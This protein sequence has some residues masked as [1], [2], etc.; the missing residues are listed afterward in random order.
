MR[1]VLV[2]LVAVLLIGA[3]SSAQAER[4]MFIIPT[5][6]DGYG[7][8]R[9]LANGEKCGAAAA[10]TYCKSQAFADAA[11]FSKVDRDDI[12]G[13]IPTGGGGCHGSKCDD[14]V[15]IVCTR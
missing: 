6:A 9:C 8:D 3:A 4:R 15:A 5:N 10:A 1:T 13:A 11:S 14:F 2:S 12:T 7:I